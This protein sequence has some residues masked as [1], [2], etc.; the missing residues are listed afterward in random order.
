[1]PQQSDR[2]LYHCLYM[3]VFF[4]G[5]RPRFPGEGIKFAVV[6]TAIPKVLC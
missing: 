3:G 2:P 6:G 5:H 4:G 1:M